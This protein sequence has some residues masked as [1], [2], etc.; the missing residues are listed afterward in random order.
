MRGM[1]GDSSK[2]GGWMQRKSSLSP[3]FVQITTTAYYGTNLSYSSSLSE[4]LGQRVTLSYVPATTADQQIVDAY[5]SIYSTPPYL[6]RVKPQLKIEGVIKSEGESVGMGTSQN[7]SMQFINPSFGIDRVE[8]EISVG[9]YYSIGLIPD[10]LT[11]SYASVLQGRA[12][13]LENIVQAGADLDSDS[14]LGEKLYLTAM[15]YFW[16]TDI[17]SSILASQK[18]IAYLKQPGEA[19]FSLSLT[20]RNLF[21]IPSNLSVSGFNIDVD[22]AIYNAESKVGNSAAGMNFLNVVGIAGSNMENGIIEQVYK[23]NSISAVKAIQLANA[24]GQ[25]IYR[26]TPANRESI[27]P[28][29]EIGSDVISDIT[30]ALNAGKE[31]LIHEHDLQIGQW[32]GAG[33]I[34]YDPNSGDGAFMISGGFSGGDS[35]E[36]QERVMDIQRTVSLLDVIGCLLADSNFIKAV[37]W[38]AF[39]I[40]AFTSPIL[41]GSL[42]VA[43]LLIIF[44]VVMIAIITE[45][46]WECEDPTHNQQ[47]MRRGNKYVV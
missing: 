20:V 40:F 39:A 21:G 47:G 5:G 28:S 23:I 1:M 33:Y 37:I 16:E 19:I 41:V 15:T 18:G 17:Q 43:V 38:L 45:M 30:N 3:L 7:F 27:L 4:L 26:I 44:Y 36:Q 29:L 14:V 11:R 6:I 8:N 22:R 24:S 10:S 46:V 34:I 42:L 31:V 25:N 35:I 9:G 13:D 2:P 32:S 12:Q